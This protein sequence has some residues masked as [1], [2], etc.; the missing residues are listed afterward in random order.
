MRDA[1]GQLAER[2]HFLRLQQLQLQV[3]L[4]GGGG[5]AFG[6][7]VQEH[8]EVARFGVVGGRDIDGELV[9]VRVR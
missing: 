9:A 3:A 4:D 1:A 6:A 7:V 8:E 2:L 5:H